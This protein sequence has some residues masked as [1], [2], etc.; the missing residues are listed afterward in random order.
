MNKP[1]YTVNTIL[2]HIHTKENW[3]IYYVDTDLGDDVFYWLSGFESIY[4]D[5]GPVEEE[6]INEWFEIYNPSKLERLIYE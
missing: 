3:Q 2:K 6:F 5:I 4:D 1:K